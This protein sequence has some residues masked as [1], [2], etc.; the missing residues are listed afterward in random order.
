MNQTWLAWAFPGLQL[1]REF[2]FQYFAGGVAGQGAYHFQA[3][4]RVTNGGGFGPGPG[5]DEESPFNRRETLCYHARVT[6]DRPS[7]GSKAQG[8]RL[9]GAFDLNKSKAWQKY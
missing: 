9:L 2:A 3:F 1:L 5:P 6:G 7:T 4:I 8:L